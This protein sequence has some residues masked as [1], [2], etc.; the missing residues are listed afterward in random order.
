MTS[1]QVV[2]LS[3]DGR[4][5]SL[6]DADAALHV[7]RLH[8]GSLNRGDCLRGDRARLGAHLLM[9]DAQH[10]PLHLSFESVRCSQDQA[11]LLMHPVAPA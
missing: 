7:A 1:Y 2:D 10:K 3:P 11:L 5:A 8:G 9:M 4:L 6:I